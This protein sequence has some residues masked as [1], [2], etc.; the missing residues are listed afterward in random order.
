MLRPRARSLSF[1]HRPDEQAQDRHTPSGREKWKRVTSA[2]GILLASTMIV[3]LLPSELAT[4]AAK[5]FK[6]RPVQET[7][8]VTGSPLTKT[9]PTPLSDTDKNPWTPPKVNWPKG[10]ESEVNLGNDGTASVKTASLSRSGQAVPYT[11]AGNLPV[12]IAPAVGGDSGEASTQKNGRIRRS[13]DLKAEGTEHPS[14]VKVRLADRDSTARAGIDGVLLSINRSDGGKKAGRASV[15][16]D[17]NAFRD[18]YGANWGARL[19]LVQLPACVLTTPDKDGCRTATPLVTHNDPK[20]GTVT[21]DVAVAEDHRSPDERADEDAGGKAPQMRTMS[22]HASAATVLAATAAPSGGEG[23]FK[24][25]PLS[26][27]GSWKAGGNAGAF[28][29]SYPMEVPSVPG[30]LKPKLGLSYS[31]AAIDGRTA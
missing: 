22:V 20:N 26:P 6:L 25:T 13:A 11:A 28:S 31:S 2:S 24:A 4:A 19:Q 15:Q 7:S 1:R 30:D 18:A 10:G 27:S 14:K 12:K 21:A 23:D 9:A 17:Y 8:S 29:W 5:D 16:L 3:S